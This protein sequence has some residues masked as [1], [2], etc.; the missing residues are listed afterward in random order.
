MIVTCLSHW[1][2]C[3]EEGVYSRFDNEGSL[4]YHNIVDFKTAGS[5]I[6]CVCGV[7]VENETFRCYDIEVVS[8]YIVEKKQSWLSSLFSS[9]INREVVNVLPV[10]DVVTRDYVYSCLRSGGVVVKG[11]IYDVPFG[12][13]YE[14]APDVLKVVA[15][16]VCNMKT[17]CFSLRGGEL[18]DLNGETVFDPE[19]GLLLADEAVYVKRI[20]YYIDE[21]KRELKNEERRKEEMALLDSSFRSLAKGRLAER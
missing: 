15:S 18:V 4:K 6:V 10:G 17:D 20:I 1:H 5:D 21:K 12:E 19:S 8:Q 3:G 16:V 11:H 13:L 9:S 14:E 7:D 2:L